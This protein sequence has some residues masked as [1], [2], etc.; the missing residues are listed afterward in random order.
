MGLRSSADNSKSRFAA[1]VEGLVGV[2]GHGDL[3][4]PLRDYCLGLIMPCERKS[5]EPMAAV[6]APD[7][8]AAQHQSLLHFVGQSPW[9]NEKVLAKVGEMILPATKSHGL[10]E[11]WIIDDTGSPKKGQHSVGVARRTAVSSVTAKWRCRCHS[12]K[13]RRTGV[14]L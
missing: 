13:K 10:I 3:A 8:T 6:T 7:R 14:R 1:D 12:P 9:P 5:F 11:A 2:I 4:G